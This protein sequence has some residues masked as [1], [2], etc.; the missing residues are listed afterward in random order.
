MANTPT[1]TT[2]ESIGMEVAK[3]ARKSYADE[4]RAASVKAE[5]SLDELFHIAPAGD[6]AERAPAAGVIMSGNDTMGV[7]A[8]EEAA[9]LQFTQFLDL[10]APEG[11]AP[12]PGASRVQAHGLSRESE[13]ESARDGTH[14]DGVI[15]LDVLILAMV[16]LSTAHAHRSGEYGL[17]FLGLIAGLLTETLS[18]R[19][20]GTHCHASS[21]HLPDISQCSSLN[22]VLYYVPWVYCCVTSA[23]RLCPAGGRSPALPW[24]AGGL[25]FGMCG[26]YEMQGPLMGWWL[27]PREDGV[28]KEGWPLWQLGDLGRDTRGL[29]VSPHAAEA[30][31][32]RVWGFP[33]LAPFFHVAF[34]WGVAAACMVA[35]WPK[36]VR[37]QL[38][39]VLLVTPL[40]MCWD[41]AFRAVGALFHCSKAAAAPVLMA[42]TLILPPMLLQ[43][44]FRRRPA[45]APVDWLL[46]G[47]PAL[48][49]AFF[50]A[51]AVWGAGSAVLP[52]ALK[53]IVC[54]VSVYSLAAHCI[55]AGL[56]GGGGGN[57]GAGE[58]EGEGEGEP[59]LGA[60]PRAGAD[61]LLSQPGRSTRAR[62]KSPAPRRRR[63]AAQA[64]AAAP[65]PAAT[66]GLPPMTLLDSL[67]KGAHASELDHTNTHPVVFA[68]LALAQFPACYA[69]ASWLA[70]PTWLA[71]APLASHA[72]MFLVSHY[73]LGHDRYF[74]ITGEST[75]LPLLLASHCAIEG[76]PAPRQTLVTALSAAWCTRLGLFLGWR[77]FARGSDWRFDKLMGGACYNAFG[78]VSQGTWIFLQG[79]AVWAAHGAD[80]GTRLGSLDALGAAVWAAGLAIEHVADMQK[81]RANAAVRSGRQ[82][83][84]LDTGLWRY[85]RHPNFFGEGLLW[86]GTAV[87]ASGGLRG[88]PASVALAFVSPVWSTFFLLFTSLM[89]LEKRMDAKFGGRPAYE[90]Y[91][92]RTS[93]LVLWP[94]REC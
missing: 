16:A 4:L 68:A 38:L 24:V 43:G 12:A 94:P 8:D 10:P 80:D 19:L 18:L 76:T 34:G 32:E 44:G 13:S 89:L 49:A 79:A 27:W 42:L 5:A 58:G 69:L 36:G 62:S 22:S 17:L 47:A 55:A 51:H 85:S 72:A 52:G 11:T 59:S 70:L 30:L 50:S 39:V 88:R 20:G 9:A 65:R 84:W 87:V 92:R 48:N 86:W 35:G 67:Q 2:K 31:G 40:A 25:F 71:L 83:T 45:G 77:I 37:A 3:W 23:R 26:V 33:V 60:K 81:T 54:A 7:V 41:P 21:P 93:V 28:V 75:M 1:P 63:G 53:A 82:R 29:V 78:W 56:V 91:K 14:G 15:A 90:R 57:G 66:A 73:A 74:D 61:G 46:I 64:T 6:A